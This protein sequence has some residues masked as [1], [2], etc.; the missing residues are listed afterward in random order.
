[1]GYFDSTREPVNPIDDL[2]YANSSAAESTNI[3]A[4]IDFT[5]TGFTIQSV[6]STVNNSGGNY[7]YMAFADTRDAKFNF[8]ASGNKNNWL[9]NNINSNAESESTYDLM[10]DTP[11]L[12]D[13]NAANFATLN[14]INKSANQPIFSNG[15]L[16]VAGNAAAY[17]N[18]V[19]SMSMTSGKWYAEIQV[20]GSLI[21][22]EVLGIVNAANVNYMTTNVAFMGSR[23]YGYHIYSGN[24]FNYGV[25]T[26]YGAAFANGDICGI[27]FDADAGTLTF[28]KN[29]VSQGVAFTGIDGSEEWFFCITAYGGGPIWNANFGQRPFAYTPPTGFLKLNTFNLPDST[30]ED[31]SDYFNTVLYTGT[32]STQTVT[33][34]FQPDFVWGKSRNLTQNHNLYDSVRGVNKALLSNS[35]LAELPAGELNAFTSDGFTLGSGGYQMN[36][37]G[38]SMVAWNWL[39]SNTTATNSA[40][41]NGATIAST[42]SAN[43]TA[44]FSIVTYT[45]NQVAGAT[46]YHGLG[47]A[48][49]VIIVKGRNNSTSGWAVGHQSL[50]W[51]SW[52][53]LNNTNVVASGAA[54]WNNTAPSANLFTLGIS[55]IANL[56]TQT[57]VAYCFAPVEGYSSFGSYTGNGSADGPFVYTGF[58]PAF[59][60]VKQSNAAGRNWNIWDNTRNTYNVI[61]NRLL[62]NGNN[63]DVV[64]SD[65]D[66]L[67]NGFKIR[68]TGGDFNLSGAT[69]IYM[70]FAENPFKNAN[71]R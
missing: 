41:T 67:S 22:A 69:Y 42:Y 55:G 68:R 59:V 19:S 30:I 24:K 15:N 33:V 7:I 1:M 25:S 45:G 38:S 34:G 64:G 14:P 66:F 58:K 53:Q 71:A 63:A 21:S 44:G 5:D 16:T 48:P 9:P 61:T 40:G 11:S 20:V 28:Y 29:G 2:V 46:V 50:G 43:P 31:G 26:A 17:N 18:T 56:N 62:P 36:T 39:A 35:A 60:L 54:L 13:E 12:V 49:Y 27:A 57:A 65:L 52:L 32:N 37:S 70:A 6:G 10:K 23:G 8:D 51:G 47:T 4:A 3:H